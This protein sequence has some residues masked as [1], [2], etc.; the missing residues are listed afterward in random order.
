MDVTS[1]FELVDVATTEDHQDWAQIDTNQEASAID[2]TSMTNPTQYAARSLDLSMLQ[3]GSV[4]QNINGKLEVP[5]F[6]V[7]GIYFIN[8][9]GTCSYH[10][11]NHS[12]SLIPASRTWDGQS[13]N[14]PEYGHILSNDGTSIGYF[15]FTSNREIRFRMSLALACSRTSPSHARIEFGVNT[16]YMERWPEAM[17][18]EWKESSA[19]HTYVCQEGVS[20]TNMDV[21]VEVEGNADVLTWLGLTKETIMET[22]EPILDLAWSLFRHSSSVP[23][24]SSSTLAPLQ[25]PDPHRAVE[26]WLGNVKQ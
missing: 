17:K 18:S 21:E 1:D 20:N 26:T 6:R 10:H 23:Q 15:K 22:E 24:P 11:P 3:P 9:L 13:L 12:V 7:G 5:P 19:R 14:Y 16:E 2:D 4:L 8:T 25:R